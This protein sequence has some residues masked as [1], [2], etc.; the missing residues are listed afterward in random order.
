MKMTQGRK[1][2]WI[3]LNPEGSDNFMVHGRT[4]SEPRF[5]K[6]LGHYVVS[7]EGRMCNDRL[8]CVNCTSKSFLPQA[9][10]DSVTPGKRAH[11]VNYTFWELKDE[12]DA[13]VPPIA[14]KTDYQPDTYFE[15][16][17]FTDHL[18][19]GLRGK[20]ELHE[21]YSSFNTRQDDPENPLKVQF[22]N[23]YGQVITHGCNSVTDGYIFIGSPGEIIKPYNIA[24]LWGED[25]TTRRQ[26]DTLLVEAYLMGIRYKEPPEDDVIRMNVNV[27]TSEI[28]KILP[29]NDY[30][31]FADDM[32]FCS[33]RDY[34]ADPYLG[35]K[36]LDKSITDTILAYRWFFNKPYLKVSLSLVH[37]ESLEDSATWKNKDE[38][39]KYMSKVESYSKSGLTALTKRINTKVEQKWQKYKE[40]TFFN[41]KDYNDSD[42][43]QNIQAE[44]A[45]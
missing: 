35:T 19:F 32:T 12:N 41:P 24:K 27:I 14:Q 36:S 37:N 31:G 8:T 22:V 38:Y 10:W 21:R 2:F 17:Q 28:I 39:S 45:E 13:T 4:Y 34:R 40:Q 16:Q 33:K 18:I 11:V 9:L 43:F 44:D 23:K 7:D 29:Q 26:L 30:Y 1:D 5:D 15:M 25:L 42:C 3:H 20:A 6:K